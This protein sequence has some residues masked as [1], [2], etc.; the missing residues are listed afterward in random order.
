MEFGQVQRA[1]I[2]QFVCGDGYLTLEYGSKAVVTVT[3]GLGSGPKAHRA[4]VLAIDGVK[5]HV[6]ASLTDI[7]TYCH[8][9]ILAAGAVGAMMAIMR[10]DQERHTLEFAGVGNIRFLAHSHEIIQPITRFG[11]LGVRLPSLREF[12]FPLSEGDLFFLHTDGISSR[13]HL[14]NHPQDL[15]KSPQTLADLLMK[16]YVK[17]HDDATAVVVRV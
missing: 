6:D 7:L 3:D 12:H 10:L 4:S 15:R 2:G 8:Y 1:K 17:E 13:F 5:E 16:Q 11:Y 14:Q 9:S